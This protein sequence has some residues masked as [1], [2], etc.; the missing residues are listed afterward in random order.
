MVV[1]SYGEDQ[2]VLL[3]ALDYRLLRALVNYALHAVAPDVARD[4]DPLT[5]A[6]HAYVDESISLSKAAEQLGISRYDLMERCERLGIPLRLGSASLDEA[7]DEV[8]SARQ[9]RTGAK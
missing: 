4:H 7:Q 2:I 8:R 9:H 6:I 3:D 5:Q 1:Q